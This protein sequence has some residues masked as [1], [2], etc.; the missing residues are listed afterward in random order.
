MPDLDF[1]DVIL[2]PTFATF[3][4]VF[5]LKETVSDKGRETN[6]LQPFDQ[7]PAIVIS[8]GGDLISNP[9]ERHAP[10]TIHVHTMF[11]LRGPS[12]GYQPDQIE[13]GG[14]RYVVIKS[15]D[16]SMYGAGFISADCASIEALDPPP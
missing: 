16:F 1:S 4:K 7:V 5:R 11:R 3:I 14:S 15:N 12:P 2:S 6:T 9:D 13:W 8:E 10:D